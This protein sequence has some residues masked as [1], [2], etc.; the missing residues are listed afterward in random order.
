MPLYGVGLAQ[1][2]TYFG[3]LLSTVLSGKGSG[4][5]DASKI[6]ITDTT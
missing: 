2:G 6:G 1:D 3:S 5:I 4:K